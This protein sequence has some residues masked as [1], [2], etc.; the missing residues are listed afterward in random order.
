[1]SA[2]EYRIVIGGSLVRTGNINAYNHQSA[3]KKVR[4]KITIVIKDKD[5]YI[6][7]HKVK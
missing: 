2:Y 1:M 4:E 5:N 7:R 3:A 6:T